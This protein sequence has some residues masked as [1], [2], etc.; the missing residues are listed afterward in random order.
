M[1]VFL[2]RLKPFLFLAGLTLVYFAALIL[3]PSYVLYSDHSDFLATFLPVKRFLVRSWQQTGELPL[4]CPDSF[5]GMPFIHDVQVG[6]FY[7]FHWPLYLLPQDWLGAAMSWL[8]VAHVFI[9]GCCMRAYGRKQGLGEIPALVAAVGY[10]FAGK[11]L[12]HVLDAGHYVM[13][14]LAWL[15]LVLLWL[16]QAIAQRSFVCATW[17]GAAFALIVLGAHPQMTFFAGLFVAVWTTGAA[18]FAAPWRA[19]LRQRPG[20]G[21]LTQPRSPSAAKRVIL[22]GSW[23]A[24]VAAALSA[25]QLLPALE[26]APES[27]RAAGVTTSVAADARAALLGLVG[28]AWSGG[29]EGHGGL[30]LLWVAAAIAAPLWYRGRVRFQA[31]VC[32]T[33]VVFSGG[34]AALFQWLPGFRLFQLPVR[35]LMLLALPVALLAGW[36]TQALLESR[37]AGATPLAAARDSFRRLLFPVVGAGLVLYGSA[38]AL[39]YRLWQ[40]DYWAVLLVITVA[41]LW[42]LG[43]KCSLGY[44]A[45]AGAWLVLLL[46]DLWGITWEKVAVRSADEIYAPSAC[47]RYLTELRTQSPQA[48]WRVLDRGLLG[49]PSSAPLGTTL[50]MYGPIGIEPVLGYNPFDLR[51]YKEYLQFIM[52][53]DEPIRPRHGIFGYPIIEGFPIRNKPLLDLL[54]TRYALDPCD[55]SSHFDAAGEPGKDASWQRVGPEDPQPHVFSFL[56]GGIQQLPPYR[57][58]ENRAAFPRAFVVHQAAPLADRSDVLAQM[59]STD[60]HR[61]VLLEGSLGEGFCPSASVA[62]APASATIREYRPNRVDVEVETTLPGYLVLADVCFPGWKGTV[63]GRPVPIQRAD[64]LF[65]AVAIPAGTHQVRFVFDPASY[66]WGKRIS[67]LTLIAVAGFSLLVWCRK[68]WLRLFG[69]GGPFPRERGG[70]AGEPTRRPAQ[71]SV[72]GSLPR[73]PIP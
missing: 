45:W 60:F 58:Y 52:D 20:T 14:P 2:G 64:F 21:V 40:K 56:A 59:K 38:G 62:D 22:L 71:C 43:K 34:G 67:V 42:L 46:A 73:T 3:H 37:G 6:A 9:A 27:T 47:V 54:G 13:I 31:G 32:L 30:G 7:P 44:R 68:K 39:N 8:V 28:P 12:L 50:P 16:E 1:P 17:A 48:H 49:Q 5:G 10:M 18:C 70:C 55:G 15:P 26:A 65:R 57:I 29:W 69:A 33:I 11:W 35:M 61:E 66:R 4:W 41:A 53:E 51:R 36:T 72:P 23:S 19:G 24:I 25:V 63:D